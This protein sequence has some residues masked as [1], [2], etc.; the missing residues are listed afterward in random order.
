MVS[1]MKKF[2]DSQRQ[3]WVIELRLPTNIL[4]SKYNTTLL[5]TTV[6]GWILYVYLGTEDIYLSS[7]F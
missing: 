2:S 1:Q 7:P 3:S 6:K 4:L 5:K